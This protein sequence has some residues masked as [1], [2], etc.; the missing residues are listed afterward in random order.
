M[1]RRV[2]VGSF[3]EWRG[4]ARTLLAQAV[5]PHDVDW[6]APGE[7]D[8]FGNDVLAAASAPSFSL[9]ISSS[10]LS[11]LE[12]ASC[13][14]VADRWA[15]LYRVL[16]RSQQGDA[17]VLSAADQDGARLHAMVKAVRREQHKMHAFLRF[18]ERGPEAGAPRFIAW[19][20]PAH[21][22]L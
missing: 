20:E 12:A 7:A 1:S 13:F 2:A 17:A 10:L 18:R 11:L 8:L 3:D 5:P 6:A 16:W 15:L 19:F 14:R 22:V 4:A 21:D 9:R